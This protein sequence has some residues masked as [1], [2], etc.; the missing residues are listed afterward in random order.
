MRLQRKKPNVPAFLDCIREI[1]VGA[2]FWIDQRVGY[3]IFLKKSQRKLGY[4]PNLENPRSYNEKI[5]WRKAYDRN[6]LFPILSDKLGVRE[7]IKWRLG[8][9]EAENMLSQIFLVTDKPEEISLDALPR[10][11]VMKAN[12][13]SGWNAFTLEGQ[14][15]D[16]KEIRKLAARWLRRSFGKNK[17]E[18][19]YQSI[20]RKVIFEEMIVGSD[21][22]MAR[23]IKFAVFDGKCRFIVL[24]DGRFGAHCWHHMTPEWTRLLTTPSSARNNPDPLRPQHFDEMLRI[25]E[26]V[27][28]GFDFFRVDFLYTD[29]RFVLNEITLYDAS[30]WDPLDPPEWDWEFGKFWNLRK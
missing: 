10:S 19:A 21:G 2:V 26:K 25:A 13:A 15:P 18:W 12:H 5:L 29:E 9:A 6:P 22:A 24:V 28:E 14:P 30:G 17:M 23:D 4:R 27:S 20:K 16:I 8:A 7:F 3:P 1:Y 11:F